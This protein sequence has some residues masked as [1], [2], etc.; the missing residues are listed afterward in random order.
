M[1]RDIE[2]E[3]I[4]WRKPTNGEVWNYAVDIIRNTTGF[5]E[6]A[7]AI[8]DYIGEPSE[9]PIRL[10][11]ALS[12]MKWSYEVKFDDSYKNVNIDTL[13]DWFYAFQEKQ[14]RKARE[15]EW[16]AREDIDELIRRV[17]VYR[18]SN[19]F[20]EMMKYVGRVSYL[21]PFNAMLVNLQKPG[22]QI[23]FSISRWMKYGRRPKLNSNPL[24]VLIPFGPVQTLYDFDSTEEIEDFYAPRRDKEG[25]IE[26]WCNVLNKTKGEI[27]PKKFDNLLS[28]LPIYGI[29]L[30]TKFNAASTYGGY[31]GK[32]VQNSNNQFKVEGLLTKD[33][34]FGRVTFS[35]QKARFIISVNKEQNREARFHTI[36]H[37][38]GHLFCRHLFY[39]TKERHLSHKEEEF[40]A[41]TVAWLMCRRH[42]VNNPS[43]QYLATYSRG[44]KVPRCSLYNMMNAVKEIE[45]MMDKTMEAKDGL[46]YKYDKDF[47]RVVD[48]KLAELEHFRQTHNYYH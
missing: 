10:Y 15:E 38:L 25:L 24:I 19:R 32:L 28:N 12:Q 6:F 30:D 48:E 35:E 43:E 5:R 8:M 31:L 37:E 27:D 34:D 46:W 29:T 16:K 11:D 33:K 23:A 18:D 13:N 22:T 39:D 42:G 41:E 2:Q 47:K 26:E 21:A 45:K 40:E 7:E 1:D 20:Y 9:E 14:E 17:E 44:G 4:E 36:C 3:E